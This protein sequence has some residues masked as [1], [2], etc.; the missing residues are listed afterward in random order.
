[1]NRQNL[2]RLTWPLVIFATG[3]LVF[4][5]RVLA[6]TDLES[7]GQPA[8]IGRLLDLMMQ[9]NVLVQRDLNGVV[10]PVPPL[11][12]WVTA[13][14][15]TVFGLGRVPLAIPSLL[16]VL[17]TAIVVFALGRRRFG[18]MAG[19]LGAIAVVMTLP[20]LIPSASHCCSSGMV[21][22]PQAYSGT[23]IVAAISISLALLTI[24]RTRS[25][26]R[27]HFASPLATS[28]GGAGWPEAA[29]RIALSRPR[30]GRAGTQCAPAR[31]AVYWCRLVLLIASKT[32]GNPANKRRLPPLTPS[33]PLTFNVLNKIKHGL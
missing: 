2:L 4:L 31:S 21:P 28:Y 3:T 15:A 17:A 7:Y 22:P 33:K 6:P 20:M 26:A 27:V 19:G 11:H 9:G 32:A 13:L 23:P 10:I 18:E 16:S 5:I 24:A 8:N 25:L 29:P 12:T 30:N 14:F 1:M